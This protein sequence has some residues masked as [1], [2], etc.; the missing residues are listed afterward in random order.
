MFYFNKIYKN[1]TLVSCSAYGEC[2]NYLKNLV[3]LLTIE[4]KKSKI[5]NGK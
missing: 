5:S 4:F 1:I 2:E 3:N